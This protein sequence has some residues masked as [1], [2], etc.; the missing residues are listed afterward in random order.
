VVEETAEA[1]EPA[2]AGTAARQAL[3]EE[4]GE[5]PQWVTWRPN[6]SA[7]A[8][9]GGSGTVPQTLNCGFANEDEEDEEEEEAQAAAVAAS[10]ED[11][12]EEEDGGNTIAKLLHQDESAWGTV[13]SGADAFI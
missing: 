1:A 6:R 13:G 11:P 5:Q 9:H 4:A 2:E 7:A 10:A 12:D 3:I 8:S